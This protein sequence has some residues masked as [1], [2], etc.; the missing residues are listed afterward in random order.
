VE[1]IL[2][3]VEAIAGG[4]LFGLFGLVLEIGVAFVALVLQGAG[5]LVELLAHVI[6]A[7]AK[8]ELPTTPGPKLKLARRGLLAVAVVLGVGLGLVETVGKGAV[9][10][11]VATRAGVELEAESVGGT[12]LGG[13]LLLQG[14]EAKKSSGA[15]HFD[16]SFERVEV[17]VAVWAS[18][19]GE[20][21][22]PTVAVAGMRGTVERTAVGAPA[23][24]REPRPM[25][26]AALSVVDTE[27]TW[28]DSAVPDEVQVE[29]RVDHFE[30]APLRRRL[31][32]FDL[33][34]RA[35]GSGSVAGRPFALET[36][37]LGSGRRTTW[38]A[39][40]LPLGTFRPYLGEVGEWITDAFLDVEVE[41]R[42]DVA[43]DDL[44]T[45]RYRFVLRDV[46]LGAPKDATARTKLMMRVMGAG[47]RFVKE[48]P[49]ELQ[50]E[51]HRADLE[52]S[53]SQAAYAMAG[54]VVG[55]ATRAA[56]GAVKGAAMSAIKRGEAERDRADRRAILDA[57]KRENGA[58][59]DDESRGI[60][61]VAPA[62]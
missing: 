61:D 8:I 47:A 60:V 12:L 27:L 20:V 39:S 26:I 35:N 13:H 40:G 42:W 16:V 5:V 33:L 28:I 17:D 55:A 18:L 37:D 51:L 54:A 34:Y 1:L 21:E 62:E 36:E 41:D 4:V 30:V 10:R 31:A 11:A 38:S 56:L 53:A 3:L 49:F 52:G 7:L 32:V 15:V 59:D 57:I 48:V 2:L 46:K 44:V 9:L 58:A 50:L 23:P 22:V 19:F 14:V 43:R 29:L 6:P 24:A 25:T 45:M